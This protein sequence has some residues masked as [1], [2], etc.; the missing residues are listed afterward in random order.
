MAGAENQ[1]AVGGQN[2]HARL[3]PVFGASTKKRHVKICVSLCFVKGGVAEAAARLAEASP[4]C[5][6]RQARALAR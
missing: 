4:S 6:E 3:L 1:E 2:G 5:A